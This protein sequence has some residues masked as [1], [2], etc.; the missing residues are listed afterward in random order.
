M[1]SEQSPG[2][3]VA[4]GTSIADAGEQA[5]REATSA[6][7]TALG[8]DRIDFC[9]VFADAAFDPERVLAG[10]RA[11]VDEDT[12]VVGC[13]AAGTFTEERTMD[14]GV[15]VGVVTSDSFQFDTAIASGLGE[16]I[17]GTVREAARA[18]PDD[19][20]YPYQS[21]LVLHDGLSGIG[22][23]LSLAIQRR[24]GP[25]VGFAG[26]AASDNFR[27]ESTP[28]FCGETVA[29]DALVLVLVSGE[30]RAVISVDHG[31]EP[32]S[33]PHEVTDVDGNLVRELDGE[34]AFEVW[35]DT[36]R[37]H[38]SETFGLD[39]DS[40]QLD[41]P[42]LQRLMGAYEFGIDQGDGYK[43]RWPRT[44]VGENGSLR[45]AVDIPEGTVLRVMHGSPDSQI[46]S[47]GRAA[48]EAVELADGEIAGG[49]V[50]DCACREIILQDEYPAAVDAL[51][52]VLDTPFA[53]FETYG[54]LCMQMGQ[55]S[56]FHNTTT[57]VFVFPE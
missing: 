27:M 21:A 26:G 7:R 43:I 24:L 15:A 40:F 22:E 34:P 47:A 13:T 25:H 49:F 11:A 42:Q 31:H 50:Y 33:E 53:G 48:S 55:L 6:A 12:A 14:R 36:V 54:E 32:I 1:S 39:V 52:D 4:T 46:E 16:N 30:D 3:V 18:L 51:A 2:T 28:V 38:V 10:V 41:A 19:V 23:R 35:K 20:D 29:E 9:Q 45:F 8:A 37:D 56:G 57:V 17:Q 44:A 5:G